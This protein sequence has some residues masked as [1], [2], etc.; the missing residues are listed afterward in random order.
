MH[1][2]LSIYKRVRV[3][4]TS[5]GT[6]RTATMLWYA[7]PHARIERLREASLALSATA[8]LALLAGVRFT[9]F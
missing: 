9:V 5:R 7:D 8:L 6:G 3:A 2:M 4:C 1:N